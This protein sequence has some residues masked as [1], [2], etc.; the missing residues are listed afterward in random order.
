MNKYIK[1]LVEIGNKVGSTKVSAP[2][3]QE[4]KDNLKKIF[5]KQKTIDIKEA[6]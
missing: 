5:E 3:R 1:E 6:K 2:T 4:I